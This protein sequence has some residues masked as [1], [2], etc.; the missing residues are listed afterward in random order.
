MTGRHENPD[1]AS[2]LSL[3]AGSVEKDCVPTGVLTGW[4]GAAITDGWFPGGVRAKSMARTALSV[5]L[6]E[7]GI[8]AVPQDFPSSYRDWV[9]EET[10]HPRKPSRRRRLGVR[11][12]PTSWQLVGAR[13]CSSVGVGA[14]TTGPRIWRERADT[15]RPD[16]F[17]EALARDP[18]LVMSRPTPSVTSGLAK[19]WLSTPSIPPKARSEWLT[20][21]TRFPVCPCLIAVP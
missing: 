5:L 7:L 18:L 3:L 19:G 1:S 10:D 4:I 17:S 16:R 11:Y 12:G 6:K 20:P 15:R 21:K 9:A 14:W 13:I 8:A 2:P